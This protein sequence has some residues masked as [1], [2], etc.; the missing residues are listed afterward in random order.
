MVKSYAVI[1]ESGCPPLRARISGTVILRAG[2][3]RLAGLPGGEP[4]GP[5]MKPPGRGR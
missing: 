1:I 3:A 4:L 5:Y 2:R